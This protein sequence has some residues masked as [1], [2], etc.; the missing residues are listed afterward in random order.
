MC[1]KNDTMKIGILAEKNKYN[2]IPKTD[3][4]I[5]CFIQYNIHDLLPVKGV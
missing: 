1:K 2:I 5:S 3:K 4:I